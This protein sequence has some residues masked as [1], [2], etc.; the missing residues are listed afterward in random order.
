MQF[1]S[2]I[3]LEKILNLCFCSVFFDS[4]DMLLL[5]IKYFNMFLSEKYFFKKLCM[6]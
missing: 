5:K 3:R 1:E 6:Y 4:F 2:V